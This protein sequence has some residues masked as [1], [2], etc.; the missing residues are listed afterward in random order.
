MRIDSDA[1]ETR[2]KLPGSARPAAGPPASSWLHTFKK[3]LVRPL[4]FLIM[5]IINARRVYGN[6]YP[7]IRDL[8]LAPCPLPSARKT[9]DALFP[10][11][12][13]IIDF[14]SQAETLFF[15]FFILL[16]S[17]NPQRSKRT[18]SEYNRWFPSIV[19]INPYS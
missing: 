17:S 12:V 10:V 16:F 1:V 15:F 11:P 2:S 6:R 4:F 5:F 18:L 7:P 19:N 14:F 3:N 9:H 8:R 13:P